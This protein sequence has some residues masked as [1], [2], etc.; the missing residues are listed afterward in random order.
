MAQ[1]YTARTL[2]QIGSAYLP[3]EVLFG[4]IWDRENFCQTHNV[5]MTNAEWLVWIDWYTQ[6]MGLEDPHDAVARW[7]L[8]G[9]PGRTIYHT[10]D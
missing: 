1:G 6:H 10:Q 4:E 9:R 3:D 8:D 7:E 2:V 5:K